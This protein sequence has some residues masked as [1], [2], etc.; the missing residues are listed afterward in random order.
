MLTHVS[1]E[2]LQ[3]IMTS[4]HQSLTQTKNS[5]FSQ[6]NFEMGTLLIY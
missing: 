3:S 4:T 2:K 6:K 5:A 1:R